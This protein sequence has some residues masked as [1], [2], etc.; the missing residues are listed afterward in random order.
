[1]SFKEDMAMFRDG[2]VMSRDI[3][4]EYIYAIQENTSTDT[5]ALNIITDDLAEENRTY[6]TFDN[7]H[8]MSDL[9]YLRGILDV[10]DSHIAQL[11]EISEGIW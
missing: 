3:L 6:G 1:M 9:N 7:S 2:L 8:L 11:D 5:P 10:Y 4:V